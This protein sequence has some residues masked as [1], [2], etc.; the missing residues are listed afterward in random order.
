[1]ECWRFYCALHTLSSRCTACLQRAEERRREGERIMERLK[2]GQMPQGTNLVIGEFGR[3]T[4]LSD[5]EK[6]ELRHHHME[7]ADLLRVVPIVQSVPWSG[8][9]LTLRSLELY[10]D[11]SL[12]SY[13]LVPT[14]EQPPFAPPAHDLVHAFRASQPQ[15]RIED[16]VGT[17]Y[18]VGFSSGGGGPVQRYESKITPHI[19]S[20]ASALRIFVRLP[21]AAGTDTTSGPETRFDIAL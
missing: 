15:F 14:T 13:L 12:L 7:G 2:Q 6:A 9:K 16:D 20:G 1:M 18:E 11:G 5:A 17:V 4:E 3:S 21:L 19:P 8:K 10:T